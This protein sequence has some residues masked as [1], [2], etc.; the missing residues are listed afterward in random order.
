MTSSSGLSVR[1]SHTV[2]QD[3]TVVVL[4]DGCRDILIRQSPQG[5]VSVTLTDWD[6]GPRPVRLEAGTRV[7][8]HRLRPGVSIPPSL[9]AVLAADLH[10]TG[11]CAVEQAIADQA[12]FLPDLDGLLPGGDR[13]LPGNDRSKRTAQRHFRA[14]GL[15]PPGLWRQLGRA[16]HTARLLGTEPHIPLADLAGLCGYSD[17]AH[18]TRDLTRWF[19]CSPAALRRNATMLAVLAEPGF[20]NWDLR[21]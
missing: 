1:W 8:G 16:R 5:Q 19:G 14:L 11:S 12:R 21:A 17:Q 20:G 15:P 2:R 3:Q 10:R 13:L 6:F 9:L 7:T 18:M 4:P